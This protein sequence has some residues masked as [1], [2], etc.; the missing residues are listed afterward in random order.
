MFQFE[1]CDQ[2]AG[3][4]EPPGPLVLQTSWG[5]ATFTASWPLQCPEQGLRAADGWELVEE[6]WASRCK[7]LSCLSVQLTAQ[8]KPDLRP[9]PCCTSDLPPQVPAFLS[10]ALPDPKEEHGEGLESRAAVQLRRCVYKASA[11]FVNFRTTE[12]LTILESETCH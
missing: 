10:G 1:D 6:G 7:G 4:R 9:D 12:N 11:E 8:W 5:R 3:W 2:P